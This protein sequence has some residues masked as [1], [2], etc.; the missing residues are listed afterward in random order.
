MEKGI[1]SFINFT[2]FTV[3][4][5]VYSF[6]NIICVQ[7]DSLRIALHYLQAKKEVYFIISLWH[8]K[9]F[10]LTVFTMVEFQNY[11]EYLLEENWIIDFL[12]NTQREI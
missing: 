10:V 7:F 5:Y 2:V 9:V 11:M 4:K 8:F 3:Q 12:F 6:K 1:Y